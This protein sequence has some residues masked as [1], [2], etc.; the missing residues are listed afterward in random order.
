MQSLDLQREV[1]ELNYA[2]FDHVCQKLDFKKEQMRRA[3]QKLM[4]G[5]S[6][7]TTFFSLGASQQ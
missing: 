5:Q 6:P 1:M 2:Q 7:Q 3:R 4:G